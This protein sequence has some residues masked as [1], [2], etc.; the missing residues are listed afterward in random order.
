[1]VG[2]PTHE[3]ALDR[4]QVAVVERRSRPSRNLK[5]VRT[6]NTKLYHCPQFVATLR[7]LRLAVEFGN[8]VG[9]VHNIKD[10]PFAASGK[11]LGRQTDLFP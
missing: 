8:R 5:Q 11:G 2:D 10:R 1:M 9:I 4:R 6:T 7:A 3:E